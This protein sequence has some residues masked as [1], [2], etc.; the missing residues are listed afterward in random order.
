MVQAFELKVDQAGIATLTFDLKGEKVNK[1]SPEVL[2]ELE[3][4]IDQAAADKSIKCLILK[5]GKEGIFIAGADLNTFKEAEKNPSLI[6]TIIDKGHRVFD[7][8]QNLPFPTVALID[9]VCLGGGTECALACTYRIATDNPK[10]SIGLPETQ[11]GIFPGWGGTQ[12]LPRLIGLQN[13]LQIIL[14]GKPVDG[15]KASKMGLVDLF[16]PARFAEERAYQFA[17]SAKLKRPDR[18]VKFT[19]YL[20]EGNP[21]GRKLLFKKARD[22]VLKVTKGHYPAPL[23]A[24]D[25]IEETHSLPLKEGLK[26]EKERF[27]ATIGNE[28]SDSIH[29]INLFFINEALKKQ[30]EGAKVEPAKVQSAGVLGAGT[31]GG[32]IAWALSNANID[33]RMKDVNWDAVAKGYEEASKTYHKLVQKKKLQPWEANQKFHRIIGTTDYR[34][35]RNCDFVI[36]AIVEN[37]DVKRKVLKEIEDV[38]APDAIIATNTSS[39]KVEDI[40]AEMKHPERFVGMHFFNPVSLMPLVEVVAGPKTS[41]R[42]IATVVELCKRMKKTPIVVGDCSGFVVNRVFMNAANEVL[43]MLEEGVPMEKIEKSLGDFGLPM[44]PFLLMDEIGIDVTYKVSKEF[45][46]VYGER[47][48]IAPLLEKVYQM[49]LLGKKGGK[50]FY[51]HEGKN[52]VPNPEIFKLITKQSNLSEEE[53]VQR[54]IFLMVNEASRCLGENVIKDPGNLD[55]ALIMGT[56]FPPFR[57]GLLRYAQ[58]QGIGNVR[59]KL[60]EFAVKYGDRYKPT[61]Y[62]EELDRKGQQFFR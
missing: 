21:L 35:F 51:I 1:F 62:L 12:R 13:A 48:K 25:L 57:G 17:T 29:L 41:P 36:E 14:T 24:L 16:V 47:M 5:S 53:I 4:V 46:Q 50:G 52:A 39:L 44:S 45:E 42:A 2:D 32:G 59:N 40:C 49:K 27:E 58:D 38:V 7:K 8:L 6:H 22:G 54:P 3:K 37:L 26:R 28:L 9:G 61:S 18:K 23:V 30:P 11:L 31:M 56:G 10:T 15:K 55:M 34:G 60:S 20:L 33:V 19:E 43:K